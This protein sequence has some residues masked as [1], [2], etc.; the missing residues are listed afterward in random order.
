MASSSLPPPSGLPPDVGSLLDSIGGGGPTALA[1]G[2]DAAATTAAPSADT[3]GTSVTLPPQQHQ[4][5]QQQQQQFDPI[6]FLNSN[7]QTEASLVSALPTL[8]T[9]ITQRIDTLDE[10]ISSTIQKQADLADITAT[11]VARARS[12]ILRLRSR[13]ETVQ[14]KAR[15]SERAVLEITRDLKRLD[16]AKRHLSRTITALKRLHMLL[17]AVDRLHAAAYGTDPFPDFATCANLIDATRLLLGHFD[18]YMGSIQK[19]RDVR[20]AV[21]TVR[22]DLREG[23]VFGFRVVGLGFLKA[24]EKASGGEVPRCGGKIKKLAGAIDDDDDDAGD[25]A[26]GAGVGIV[27]EE[28]EYDR[29]S[30]S[31]YANA[32]NDSYGGGG[33][34]LGLVAAAAAAAGRSQQPT[35]TPPPP[36]PKQVLSDA[37]MVIDALGL[38]TRREFVGTFCSDHLETY[39]DLFDPKKSTTMAGA[40]VISS[41][42]ASGSATKSFKIAIPATSSHGGDGDGDGGGGGRQQL[43][44]RLS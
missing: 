2:G 20:D 42:A 17:H 38:P 39:S 36:M 12:A 14:S 4:Q 13:V 23:A 34:G 31:A 9:T 33:G 19:M 27:E 8:R 10:S 28:E 41:A 26:G 6:D 40:A 30:S 24:L 11:D 29:Y 32:A 3:T 7:Y 1:L 5:Q 43:Q 15:L 44:P 22:L 37:C 35:E 21:G 18:G 25:G 16:F